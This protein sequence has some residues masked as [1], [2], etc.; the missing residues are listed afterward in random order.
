MVVGAAEEAETVGQDLQRPLAEQQA[1]RLHPLLEDFEDQILLFRPGVVGEVVAAGLLDQFGHRH[2]LQFGDVGVAGLL[3]L[4]V[5]FIG[6]LAVAAFFDG[7]LL[8]QRKRL[9][10]LQGA[11]RLVERC[12]CALLDFLTAVFGGGG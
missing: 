8:G 11:E 3:D 6:V 1:V 12:R 9:L 2:P 5:V 4:F 10:L 7:D